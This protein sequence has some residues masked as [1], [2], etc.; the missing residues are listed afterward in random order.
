MRPGRK[1]RRKQTERRGPEREN[2]AGEKENGNFKRIKGKLRAGEPLRE[3]GRRESGTA[4]PGFQKA[5]K[6]REYRLPLSLVDDIIAIETISFV[7][8][9]LWRLYSNR[10]FCPLQLITFNI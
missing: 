4:C 9:V 7:R 1:R 3:Q 5:W 8:F 6:N 2:G 10:L